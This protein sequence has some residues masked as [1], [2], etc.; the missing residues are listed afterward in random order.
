[1]SDYVEKKKDYYLYTKAFV[2]ANPTLV[3]S[4][5]TKLSI[6]KTA[7]TVTPVEEVKTSDPVTE[8]KTNSVTETQT[9][10]RIL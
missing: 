7:S 4:D 1:L 9:Q 5:T 3:K 2:A 10:K 6:P 8:V